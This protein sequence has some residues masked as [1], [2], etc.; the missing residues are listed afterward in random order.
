MPNQNLSLLSGDEIRDAGLIVDGS[1]AMYRA[2]TYDLS[3]GDIIPGGREPAPLPPSGEFRLAPGGMI[4]VVARES[5]K[6]PDDVTGHALP[7]NTLCTRG[8]LAIN[9]G[10]VDPGFEGRSRAL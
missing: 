9:I 4:R 2:S 8:V 7:R 5:L 1:D 6:L 3:I 10:V